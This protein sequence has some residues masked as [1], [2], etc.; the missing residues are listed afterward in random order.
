[1]FRDVPATIY[2]LEYSLGDTIMKISEK[3]AW[4]VKPIQL[5]WF[6]ACILADLQLIATPWI[7]STTIMNKPTISEK[8]QQNKTNKQKAAINYVAGMFVI[9][10]NH[11]T[12]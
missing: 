7:N 6:V 4:I 8:K 11:H 9:F 1:M 3:G 2:E 10:G 12:M 5:Q